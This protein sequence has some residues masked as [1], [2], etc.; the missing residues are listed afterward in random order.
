MKKKDKNQGKRSSFDSVR[1]ASHFTDS[2]VSL[3]SILKKLNV[4][5]TLAPFD[6]SYITHSCSY[7]EP[8]TC[9]K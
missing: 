1:E 4:A 3:Q 5:Y 9:E 8:L 2:N 7:D 6:K